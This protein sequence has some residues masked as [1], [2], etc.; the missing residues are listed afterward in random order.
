MTLGLT[1]MKLPLV[2]V[3]RMRSLRG[4]EDAPPL[5]D[6]L[7]ERLLRPLAFGDVARGLGDADDFAGGRADRGDAQRN[8][9][10]AAV[11]VHAHGFVM[12]DRLAA[13]DPLEDAAYLVAPVRRDDDVDV[14]ADRFGRR[15]SR[16]GVRRRRSSR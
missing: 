16:T 2:S 5:L 15:D 10:A 6:L 7:A 14:L 13:A 8:I 1:W 4:L 11:L 12:F 9:D 3:T